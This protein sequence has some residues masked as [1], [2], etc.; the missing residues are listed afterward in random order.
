MSQAAVIIFLI[1]IYAL[2][3]FGLYYLLRKS[4]KYLAQRLLLPTSN[5]SLYLQE[6]DHAREEKARKR[7][8]TAFILMTIFSALLSFHLFQQSALMSLTSSIVC[9]I[10]AMIP[11][12][13]VNYYCAY[14]KRGTAWLLY[15]IISTPFNLLFLIGKELH[16]PTLHWSPLVTL[17]T[18][19][20]LTTQIYF[21]VES[22]RLRKVN[23]IR[24]Y[25][26]NAL[27]LKEK[28]D[29]LK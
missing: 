6:I 25:H 2:I 14:K 12:A 15:L 7:W 24:R 19:L 27:V 8:L 13:F 18:I 1:F 10:L 16:S 11:A 26:K 29:T 22:I 3:G 28:F 17:G 9:A 21:W 20:Y 23:L 5:I 4:S